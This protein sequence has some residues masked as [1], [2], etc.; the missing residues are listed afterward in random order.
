[1]NDIITQTILLYVVLS[2]IIV[3]MKKSLKWPV[4]QLAKDLLLE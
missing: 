3:N 4:A 1:M 2:T